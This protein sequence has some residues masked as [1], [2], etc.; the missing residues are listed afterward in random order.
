MLLTDSKEP[1][2]YHLFSLTLSIIEFPFFF[3]PYIFAHLYACIIYTY[4]YTYT[5][6]YI[7][8]YIRIYKLYVVYACMHKILLKSILIFV[9]WLVFNSGEGNIAMDEYEL[10]AMCLVPQYGC[11]KNVCLIL[12]TIY[13]PAIKLTVRQILSGVKWVSPHQK[14]YTNKFLVKNTSFA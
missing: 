9:Y 3:T 13:I 11:G 7:H 12:N 14:Y 10:I 2:E 6:S 5:Y 1:F 8:T 4:I